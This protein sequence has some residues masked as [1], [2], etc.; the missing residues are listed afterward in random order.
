M[1]LDVEKTENALISYAKSSDGYAKV[2]M[3]EAQRRVT[4]MVQ[5]YQSFYDNED[6][7]RSE[8]VMNYLL[9]NKNDLAVLMF[10]DIFPRDQHQKLHQEV[11]KALYEKYPTNSIVA[12]RYKVESSPASSTAIGAM[13][14]D[15]AFENPNGKIMKLSDLKGKVVLLDFWAGWC[16]PCRMENPNV[17]KLYNKFHDKGFEIYSVSLD[18]EKSSWVKAIEADGLIWPNHVSDLGYWNSQAAKIY[19]VSSIP[20]TFLIG[21]DGRI[22]AKNLRGAALENALKELFE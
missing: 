3:Q 13:A 21:K 8:A 4:T 6:K 1:C 14:P 18:R 11:I 7:N 22:I 20:A 9:T 19:G 10:I 17:V 2:A 12:E 16:R 15:L 5:G